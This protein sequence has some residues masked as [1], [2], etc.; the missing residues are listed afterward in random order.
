M[1]ASML[2]GILL[3][4]GEWAWFYYVAMFGYCIVCVRSLL[5]KNA[6]VRWFYALPLLFLTSFGGG[7]LVPITLGKPMV[8]EF[9]T[10]NG[11]AL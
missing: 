5:E 3:Y 8:R 2:R 11:C 9:C 10:R 6:S 4:E 7:I 1:S